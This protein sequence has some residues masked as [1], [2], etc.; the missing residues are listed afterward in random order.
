MSEPAPGQLARALLRLLF[1]LLRGDDADVLRGDVEER[2]RRRHALN[3]Q[4]ANRSLLLDALTALFWWWRPSSVYRRRMR[5]VSALR[6]R[7][8]HPRKDSFVSSFLADIRLTLRG[9]ARRPAFTITV[10]LTFAVGIGATSTIYSVVDSVV[11]RQLPYRDAD[12]LVA[13]G[14]TFPDREWHTGESGLQQLA[15]VSLLNF[16]EWE[17]RARSFDRIAAAELTSSLLPD[18]GAGPELATLGMV[19]GSFFDVFRVQPML[20]RLFLPDDFAGTNGSVVILSYETWINRFG[21]DATVINASARTA[22][23]GFTVVGVLPQGFVP[24][25]SFSS[26]PIEFWTPIDATHPRY[27]SRGRRSLAVYGRL[28]PDVTVEMA[29]TELA[30]IQSSLA[31]EYPD[32]NVYPNGDRLGAGANA[33]LADTVGGSQRLLLVF[34]GAAALLLVIAALNAANLL[35]VRGLDREGEMSV[36]RALGASRGRLAR[37][38]FL[39]SVMLALAGGALGVGVAFAGVKAFLLLAPS[40]LPRLDEVAV[41]PRVVVVTALLS[42]CAGVLVALAPVLRLTGRDI[43]T[44]MRAQSGNTA[45]ASGT[46]LRSAMIAGQLGLAVILAVGASLLMNSFIQV[47][48]VDPGFNPANLT[49]FSMP[50]KRPN[51]P[52]EERSSQAWDELLAEVGAVAGVTGV[53]AT[54][55]LPF[56]SPYWAPGVILPSDSPEDPRR[57]IAGYVI[58]PNYFD[59]AEIRVVE[60]RAFAAS[61]RATTAPVVVVN[62][63]FVTEHLGG[64]PAV[65]RLF[66]LSSADGPSAPLEIVGVVANVIQTRAEE[67]PKPA[68]YVPYTQSDWS[69]VQVLARSPLPASTIMPELRRAAARFSA[70]VP[71]QGLGDMASRVATVQTEPRFRAVLVGLFAAVAVL[72]A[73]V[74]LYG[75]LAYSVSRRRR[76]IGIRM[77]LGAQPGGIFQ[78]ILRQGLAV[79]GLGIAI[80]LGGSLLLTRLLQSFLFGVEPLDPVSFAA[81]LLVLLLAM[82]LAIVIPSRRATGVDVVGSLRAD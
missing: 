5:A 6:H 82:L 42:V 30:N 54:S 78:L 40:S 8:P 10:L 67:G 37:V 24:P 23:Q 32:G 56:Q 57:G 73:A 27:E 9:F 12:Q 62:E 66:S 26:R 53:A 25:E 80:G 51:A 46:R 63:Q 44:T 49:V 33:L 39:E 18:E 36:R 77:A 45:S 68:V 20:G 11:L 38:L 31:D 81:A 22:S 17:Q 1:W 58:T 72:L 65:G 43:A 75:T 19:S 29:R 59:V 3:P 52:A 69:M 60:G 34:L 79:T 35:L 2:Y 64:A 74:G 28:A 15:G 70:F 71:I 21:G 76:E 7:V 16:Q 61:D 4:Q 47:S 41:N 14:N 48:T 55:N 13:L 50:L